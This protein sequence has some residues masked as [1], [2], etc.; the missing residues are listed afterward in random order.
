MSQY[1]TKN[2][3]VCHKTPTIFGKSE[4]K[5][6]KQPRIRVYVNTLITSKNISTMSFSS[7]SQ[8]HG[9]DS[10]IEEE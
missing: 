3:R 5:L 4:T 9:R 6:Q 8:G 7:L 1:S 2:P 10:V